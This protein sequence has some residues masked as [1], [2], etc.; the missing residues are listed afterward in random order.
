[1]SR[2]RDSSASAWNS[3]VAAQTLAAARLRTPHKEQGSSTLGSAISTSFAA[4]AMRWRLSASFPA[5]SVSA[6]AEVFPSLEASRSCDAMLESASASSVRRVSLAAP[7]PLCDDSGVERSRGSDPARPFFMMRSMPASTCD[8]G[9]GATEICSAASPNVESDVVE[10]KVAPVCDAPGVCGCDVALVVALDTESRRPACDATTVNVPF[11]PSAVI[12]ACNRFSKN[13]SSRRRIVAHGG[14]M[15]SS[16]THG[17]PFAR[18][19]AFRRIVIPRPPAAAQYASTCR[20][21]LPAASM[22]GWAAMS[23]PALSTMRRPLRSRS[24]AADR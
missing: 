6:D 1:M 2:A 5:S 10:A 13:S 24:S 23:S 17:D 11:E 8:G 12:G 20:M 21:S 22:A 19:P 3:P 4:S 14:T 15:R 16:A 9:G 18:R 7:W